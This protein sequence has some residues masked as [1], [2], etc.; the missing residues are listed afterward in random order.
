MTH[1]FPFLRF[2]VGLEL[3]HL[4][5][6]DLD[7]SLEVQFELFRNKGNQNRCRLLNG[8]PN[9]LCFGYLFGNYYFVWI[10]RLF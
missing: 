5:L 8:N 7:V 9:G 4:S 2:E 1:L 3:C 6:I 10:P